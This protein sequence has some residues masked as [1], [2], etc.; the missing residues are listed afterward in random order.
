MGEVEGG[1]KRDKVEDEDFQAEENRHDLSKGVTSINQ[2]LSPAG[3]RGE[4]KTPRGLKAY[5]SSLESCGTL[6][7]VDRATSIL[8]ARGLLLI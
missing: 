6:K 1:G 3:N 4:V 2:N 5:G 8:G 7:W